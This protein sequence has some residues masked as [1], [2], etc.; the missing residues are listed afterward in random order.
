[1][2][3]PLQILSADFQ[4][5]GNPVN[6]PADNTLSLLE[7]YN[8]KLIDVDA[9]K[10]TQSISRRD[11]FS[12]PVRVAWKVLYSKLLE[13]YHQL[14]PITVREVDGCF[15]VLNNEEL[16]E[17][18]I[19]SGYAQISVIRIECDDQKAKSIQSELRKLRPEV[20]YAISLT[21]FTEVKDAVKKARKVEKAA[22]NVV[23]TTND[24]L[25]E[26]FDKSQTNVKAMDM[27]SKS[28]DVNKIA[29]QLDGGDSINKVVNPVKKKSKPEFKICEMPAGFDI[30]MLCPA[31]PER[32]KFMAE[33]EQKRNL[34]S[35]TNTI[36]DGN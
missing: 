3:N 19:E 4:N 30:N 36:N 31:C 12:L 21:A 17:V 9:S 35:N 28:A 25:S 15:E 13:S 22:G 29:Q 20:P 14:V 8:A 6:E 5:F 33:I 16:T 11:D 18:M 24:I 27:L 7:A 10:L 2:S 26:V 1:M 23:P 32:A 34:M